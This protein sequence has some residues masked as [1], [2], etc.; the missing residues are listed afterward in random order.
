MR[1]KTSALSPA[2]SCDSTL[3]LGIALEKP[4][5]AIVVVMT[6]TKTITPNALSKQVANGITTPIT[7]AI[8]VVNIVFPRCVSYTSYLAYFRVFCKTDVLNNTHWI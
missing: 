1:L 8:E 2:I 4:T 3:A 7:V 5:G 6:K